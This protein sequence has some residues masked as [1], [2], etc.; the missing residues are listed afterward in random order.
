MNRPPKLFESP[1]RK[2]KTDICEED[3]LDTYVRVIEFGLMQIPRSLKSMARK[4]RD[5][6][7]IW[8]MAFRETARRYHLSLDQKETII[9][10]N[11]IDA[12]RAKPAYMVS[13]TT[14]SYRLIT[15]RG[16]LMLVRPDDE[17]DF[18]GTED[19]WPLEK[20]PESLFG[21]PVAHLLSDFF[22]KPFTKTRHLREG[23]Y[24]V[25]LR[26][27]ADDECNLLECGKLIISARH[28]TEEA[29]HT[30]AEVPFMEDDVYN[31]L[32]SKSGHMVESFMAEIKLGSGSNS[33]SRISQDPLKFDEYELLLEFE[34][35]TEDWK[36]GWWFDG[37]IL[38][39]VKPKKLEN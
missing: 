29:F 9:Y 7:D 38:E 22:F 2:N 39:T 10:E 3:D 33:P 6:S 19:T 12:L 25:H 28:S 23:K 4:L 30:L 5:N 21:E 16:I 17:W 32:M 26:H 24:R 27:A 14:N 8:K 15:E 36:Q 1:L 13:D 18:K 35:D 11:Y 34:S 37:F 20:H 31:E